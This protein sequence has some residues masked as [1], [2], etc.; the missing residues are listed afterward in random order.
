MNANST[1][2]ISPVTQHPNTPSDFNRALALPA[3][4]KIPLLLI[5]LQI[6]MRFMQIAPAPDGKK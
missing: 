2:L 5:S 6:F 1:R 3:V 4:I